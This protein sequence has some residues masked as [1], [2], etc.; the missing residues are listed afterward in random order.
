MVISELKKL[1]EKLKGKSVDTKFEKSSVVRQPN[2]FRFQKLS[3]LGVIHRTS[4]SRPR[5][6][7]TQMKD[8]VVQNNSQV[9]IK[10]KE[11]E[12]H[13]RISSFSNKIKSVTACNDSLKSRTL[14]VNVACVT[15]GKCV[16]NSNHDACV[17]MFIDDVNARTK[18]P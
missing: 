13:H 1:I 9:K 17:S 12:D 7:S 16:F 14:N 15:C 11:V 4:I 8:N 2:A 3:A 6:R 5:L 10:Q 18:Q